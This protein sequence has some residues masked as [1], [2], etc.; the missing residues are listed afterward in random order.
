[1]SLSPARL[2]SGRGNALILV[3]AARNDASRAP[4]LLLRE[5]CFRPHILSLAWVLLDI[6]Q[7]DGE[8]G[9]RS[10]LWTVESLMRKFRFEVWIGHEASRAVCNKVC[11]TA[12]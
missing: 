5:V 6:G 7:A 9:L 2:V 4:S 10:I 3:P 12:T 1:M 11:T 8:G